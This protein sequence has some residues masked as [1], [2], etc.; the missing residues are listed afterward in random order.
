MHDYNKNHTPSSL[1]GHMPEGDFSGREF[2][3]SDLYKQI[4]N[5]AREVINKKRKQI[6]NVDEY[7]LK[8]CIFMNSDQYT[9]LLTK[10]FGEHITVS[11][12]SDG[13]WTG[14]DYDDPT[15]ADTYEEPDV[16]A[17]LAE[18]FGVSKI[19]DIH[20]D[21]YNDVGVWISYKL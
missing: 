4:H 15:E 10:L 11:F 1:A 2:L 6:Q 16:E 12:D 9:K 19:E 18:Y 17:K 21:D 14:Y 20:M 5:A 3:E 7:T 8:T 13:I